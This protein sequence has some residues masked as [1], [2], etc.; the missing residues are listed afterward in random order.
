MSDVTSDLVKF[1][2]KCYLQKK[3]SNSAHHF[4]SKDYY[5]SETNK[6]DIL[7]VIGAEDGVH[8]KKPEQSHTCV[9]VK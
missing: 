6:C 8:E 7:T 9:G 4:F 5:F 1:L 3:A 2:S